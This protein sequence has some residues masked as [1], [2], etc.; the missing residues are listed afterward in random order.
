MENHDDENY[1]VREITLDGDDGENLS[2]AHDYKANY[3]EDVTDSIPPYRFNFFDVAVIIIS[4]VSYLLDTGTD[5]FLVALF[6]H[7]GRYTYS[8]LTLIWIVIPA[9]VM[10]II[11]L[12][13]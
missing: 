8:I 11:G 6:Y 7:Q 9:L 2:L 1:H 12:R 4:I 5:I 3:Q 13:W 10:T